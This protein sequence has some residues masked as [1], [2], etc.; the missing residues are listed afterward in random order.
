MIATGERAKSEVLLWKFAT[1]QRRYERAERQMARK[2]GTN[3]WAGLTATVIAPGGS[4][5][6]FLLVHLDDITERKDREATLSRQAHLDALT[7]VA[8]RRVL[9]KYLQTVVADAAQT[10]PA[11]VVLYCD[12]DRLKQINDRYGH[13]VGDLVLQE[14]VL[15][16]QA[17]VRSADVIAR[18]GGDD[19]STADV[20]T[21][22]HRADLAMYAD[23]GAAPDR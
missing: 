5:P 14:T 8:N 15:R 13:A 20:E 2:D 22:L 19:A 9:L 1:G 21:L 18:L 11:G 23:K 6:S 12:L 4:Q 17:Q 16:L 7:G 3:M 10:G